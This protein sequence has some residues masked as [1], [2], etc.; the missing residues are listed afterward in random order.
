MAAKS[1][2][3]KDETHGW[4]GI[5]FQSDPGSEPSDILLHVAMWDRDSLQQAEAIGILGVN[6]IHAAMYLNWHPE[7]IVNALLDNL[8]IERI[9]VDMI[10]F[11]GKE[12]ASV[13]NRLLALQLVEKGLTNA[14]MFMPDGRIVQPADA[15]YKR[16]SSWSADHSGRSPM[17]PSTCCATHRLSSFRSPMWTAK[18]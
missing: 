17:S 6:L 10:E 18:T 13:D 8:S 9:E 11:R 2:Q 4:M 14:A 1:F 5:R 12:F 16:A 7:A 3:R 15:L